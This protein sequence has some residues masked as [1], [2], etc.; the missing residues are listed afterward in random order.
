MKYEIGDKISFNSPKSHFDIDGHII[1]ILPFSRYKVMGIDKYFP[2]IIED[3][4]INTWLFRPYEEEFNIC[5]EA[6]YNKII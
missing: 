3:D 5:E 2:N 1:K 4:G 6:I